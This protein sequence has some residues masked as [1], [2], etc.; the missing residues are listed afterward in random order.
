[1]DI[2]DYRIQEQATGKDPRGVEKGVGINSFSKR[3]KIRILP[4]CLYVPDVLKRDV[5]AQ[6]HFKSYEV[7]LAY[8]PMGRGAAKQQR[9]TT[10]RNAET[11]LLYLYI[12]WV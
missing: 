7:S 4:Q 5:V 1:M 12:L 3:R 6:S 9:E 8:A 10:H 2:C 11:Y